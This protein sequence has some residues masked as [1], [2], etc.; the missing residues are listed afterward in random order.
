MMNRFKSVS[1]VCLI[2]PL[3]CFVAEVALAQRKS[4]NDLTLAVGADRTGGIVTGNT[5]GSYS[6]ASITNRDRKGNPCMGY[7]DPQP[8]HTITLKGNFEQLTLQIDSRGSDTTLLVKKIDNH[9]VRCGFGQGSSKDA[10]IQDR[11]WS[12]GTYQ[13]WVG[14]MSPNQRSPYRLSVQP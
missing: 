12:A 7:G 13:I 3:I 4:F 1:Y 8:D 10:V 5:G 2:I 6:L 11:N 9:Y 14:S